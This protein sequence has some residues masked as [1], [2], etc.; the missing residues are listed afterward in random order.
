MKLDS[1]IADFGVFV[2]HRGRGLF[3][4]GLVPIGLS[5]VLGSMAVTILGPI[6]ALT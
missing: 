1:S 5:A 4:T 6:H 2:M 3:E